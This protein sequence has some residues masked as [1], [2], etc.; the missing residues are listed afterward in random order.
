MGRVPAMNNDPYVG[1]PVKVLH[2]SF[3][4]LGT[5]PTNPPLGRPGSGRAMGLL[6]VRGLRSVNRMSDWMLSSESN[7]LLRS[8]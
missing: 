8:L 1:S 5:H 3:T 7:R 6:V 4:S 2:T